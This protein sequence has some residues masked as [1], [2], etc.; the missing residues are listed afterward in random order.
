[1]I[2]I[3]SFYCRRRINYINEFTKY[4]IKIFFC[5]SKTALTK[6]FSVTLLRI[7]Y[8]SIGRFLF[9]I[10]I[11]FCYPCN[12][13][14]MNK[15]II[16]TNKKNK[17]PFNL[18]LSFLVIVEN[19]I[20]SDEVSSSFYSLSLWLSWASSLGSSFSKISFYFFEFFLISFI[21][22]SSS[23]FLSRSWLS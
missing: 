8:F 6:I 12:F 4:C 18:I 19:K 3:F 13:L 14:F 5:R 22:G 17:I 9:I 7:S 1:M 20:I 21:S 2:S 16:I 15:H 23:W 11:N 10:N